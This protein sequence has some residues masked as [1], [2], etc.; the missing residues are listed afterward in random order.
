MLRVG[1]IGLGTIAYIHQ[2]GIDHSTQGELVAVCDTDSKTQQ[3]YEGLPFYNNVDEMLEK[4]NLDVVHIC[5][6]HDLHVPI[7]K[8]C[9]KYGVHVFLEKPVSLTYEEGKELAKVAS[10]CDY[11]LGV[12]FQNRY[13]KTSEKLL[14]ILQETPEEELGSLVAVKGVVTWF[15]PESYYEAQ[16]WRG[17]ME[18]AGGGT[19]INQSIHTLDLM[20]WFAGKVQA[21]KGELL[22]LLN[23]D[24]EVEDTAVANFDFENNVSGLYFA[25]N[26]YAENSSVEL[27]VLTQK[28]RYVI[29]DYN[30][31]EYGRNDDIGKLIV[32]DDVFESTKAYYGMGHTLAIENFYKAI[33][34]G[35]EEYIT[36][37]EALN[38]ML[39]IDLMRESTKTGEKIYVKETEK[40]G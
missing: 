19:I 34:D 6:P 28:K 25:T 31:Y 10:E 23:Y 16:P 26:A 8:K 13:N 24:I 18:R 30:L 37:E 36:V 20:G 22:N 9:L 33:V 29:K 15:R 1:I 40:V 39:M 21:C 3:D 32:S 35:T 27:E 14:E 38:S 5:L 11:K 17:Q 7:A 4:E 12:C 2:L